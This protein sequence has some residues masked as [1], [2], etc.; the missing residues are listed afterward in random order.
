MTLKI[1][2]GEIHKQRGTKAA[3]TKTMHLKLK[4][5]ALLRLG[6]L[7]CKVCSF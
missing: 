7:S 6:I 4:I 3:E 2:V 5:D 1:T